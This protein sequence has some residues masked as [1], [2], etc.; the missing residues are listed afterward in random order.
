MKSK[1]NISKSVKSSAYYKYAILTN[2]RQIGYSVRLSFR[3]YLACSKNRIK[4][5]IAS[6]LLRKF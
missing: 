6:T 5:D 2:V 3:S 1:D 4:F